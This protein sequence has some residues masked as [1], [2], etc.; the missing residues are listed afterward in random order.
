[1]VSLSIINLIVALRRPTNPQSKPNISFSVV[2]IYAVFIAALFI[3][4]VSDLR[5]SPQWQTLAIALTFAALAIAHILRLRFRRFILKPK[6]KAKSRKQTSR[7][8]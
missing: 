2:T 5:D 7:N 6:K 8:A 4:F 3:Y 1:L